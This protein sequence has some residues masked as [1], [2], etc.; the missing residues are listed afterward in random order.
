MICYLV[1]FPKLY[2]SGKEGEHNIM[3]MELLGKNLEEQMKI[4]GKK[5]TM[6]TI[7]LIAD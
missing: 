2:W 5:F 4:V 1:G 6:K 7:L 3:V